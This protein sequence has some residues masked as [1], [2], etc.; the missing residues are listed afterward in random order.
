MHK[1]QKKQGQVRNKSPPPPRRKKRKRNNQKGKIEEKIFVRGMWIEC[2]GSVINKLFQCPNIG[3]D[4]YSRLREGV[5]TEKLE[6]V[7]CQHDKNTQWKKR[8]N[9]QLLNFHVVALLSK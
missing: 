2:S 8:Q 5:D 7:I 4:D 3:Q 9:N 6:K 1:L